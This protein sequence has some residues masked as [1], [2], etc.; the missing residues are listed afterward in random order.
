MQ[1][2]CVCGGTGTWLHPPHGITQCALYNTN[3]DT[4]TLLMFSMF[5]NLYRILQ[6]FNK[7]I[8]MNSAHISY[9]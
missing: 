3:T 5:M 2:V 4:K 7:I 1:I 6:V 9:T 8:Q